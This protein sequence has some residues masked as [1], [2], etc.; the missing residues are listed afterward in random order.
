ML[1][2]AWSESYAHPLPFGHR[3]PMEKYSLLPEQLVYEGTLKEENFFTPDFLEKKWILNTHDSEYF[4]RLTT[5]ELSR[6]EIRAT[7]FPLSH[8]LVQREIQIAA[9]SVQAAVYS[10]SHGIGMNVAGGTH[11]AFSNRGEG[12]CLL[13]DIAITANFLLENRLVSRVLV[14]DLDVHQGN[15]TAEIFKGRGD[16][17]TFSMHGEKNYPHRKEKSNLDIGF[18]DGTGDVVYLEKLNQTLPLILKEFKP[19]FLIYQCGVDV[20]ASDQ[21]G[22]LNISPKGVKERDKTVLTF[23]KSNHIPVMCCMG[24]GYS[25]QIKDIIDGHAQVFRLAQELYF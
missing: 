7:G 6:A 20:L 24:G 19:D 8:E 21:L 11:H 13:N 1:K 5:L 10:L 16:V 12:F 15:G 2:V 23:A 25:K 22:R 4:N 18:A 17:F 14:V 9:G 3:F